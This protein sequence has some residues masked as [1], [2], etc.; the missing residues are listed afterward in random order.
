MVWLLQEPLPDAVSD[1]QWEGSL[2]SWIGLRFVTEA[3]VFFGLAR[4]DEQD[5]VYYESA[6]RNLRTPICVLADSPVSWPRFRGRRDVV[7]SSTHCGTM[8]YV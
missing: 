7:T 1:P 3:M 8:N 5:P 6:F 4:R 2:G